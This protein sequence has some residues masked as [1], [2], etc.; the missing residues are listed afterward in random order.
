MSELK[1]MQQSQANKFDDLYTPTGVTKPMIDEIFLNLGVDW[2][3][4]TFWECCDYGDSFI[5]KDLKN[6]GFKVFSSG[7][8]IDLT[9][10]HYINYLEEDHLGSLEDLP[11]FPFIITNPPYSLKDKFLRKVVADIK[12]NSIKGAAL[13]LPT[14][15]LSGSRRKKIFDEAVAARIDIKIIAFA[16]RVDFTGKGA[17]WFDVAWFIFSKGFGLRTWDMYEYTK[18][19]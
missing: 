10:G 12:S 1:L 11:S 2:L 3:D 5:A 15:A 14:K 8:D 7:I 13:L 17:N 16:G 9:K 18:E 19:S 6:S 4:T